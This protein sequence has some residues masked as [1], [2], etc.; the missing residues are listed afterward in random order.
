MEVFDD[1]GRPCGKRFSVY[2]NC[3]QKFVQKSV[4]DRFRFY[5]SF[6]SSSVMNLALKNVT[7]VGSGLMG[8]GIAQVAAQTGHNVTLVDV[9]EP[10]LEK[11]HSRIQKSLERVAK[12]KF[13]DNAQESEKFIKETLQKLKTTTS[14]SDSVKEADI[15]IE[16]IVEN[17]K[18]KHELFKTL[19]KAAPKSTIFSSNTSSLSITEIAS[20]TQRKDRFG[21][22]HF[23][24]PVPV[25]KLLEVIRTEETSDDTYNKL[26]NF[27]KE[28]GKTTITCK[29]TP[30][31]V[32]NRLLVPYMGEA[33]RMLE[34][35]DATARDIDTAMK[36]GAGYPMGPFELLDYV[37]LDTTLFILEG[38]HEKYPEN[39]LFQPSEMLKKLV[40]EGKLGMKTGEGMAAI[41]PVPRQHAYRDMPKTFAPL[42]ATEI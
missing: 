42:P 16:A 5:R 13:S 18:V 23:F 27:G 26:M 7:V 12:K 29:D 10:I 34:R 32:V 9:S 37:G 38:W 8:S 39:P 2:V 3:R 28:L 14:P 40:S 24:N 30:G 4:V 17:M 21:G 20:V 11:A 33:V 36:L 15:V 41:S 1:F 6:S 25:M 22:L 19:D 35:G 31:F